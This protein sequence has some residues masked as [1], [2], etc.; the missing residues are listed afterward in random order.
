M[1]VLDLSQTFGEKP[2]VDPLANFSDTR[3][4]TPGVYDVIRMIR[5]AKSDSSI[6][7]I[8]IKAIPMP[9]GLGHH[10]RNPECTD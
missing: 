1:L 6:K 3:Y 9:N 4:N 8:Y 7:G 5:Y 2:V 10:R